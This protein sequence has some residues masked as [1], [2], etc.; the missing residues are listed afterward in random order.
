MDVVDKSD[1]DYSIFNANL[2]VLAVIVDKKD[3]AKAKK[4][5]LSNITLKL[6][7]RVNV[8]PIRP[9]KE[10][11]TKNQ[12]LLSKE[13]TEE[14]I[15]A[16]MEPTGLTFTVSKCTVAL[17]YSKHDY[18]QALKKLLPA[19]LELPLSFETVGHLAHVNLLDAHG[20]HRF[21]I[22]KVFL[23]KH[24][25]ITTVVNKTSEISNEFRV[26]PMEVIG[27][28]PDFEVAVKEGGCTFQL[29]FSKVYWNS[30]LGTEHQRL[31]GEITARSPGKA[32]VA[33]L[34]CGVGP[35]V[36]PL[37]K[38]GHEVYG[39]DLNPDSVRYMEI[40]AKK[41][42]PEAVR[43]LHP[44]LGDARAYMKELIAQRVPV[45]DV[46]MN[47]PA[48]SHKFVDVH[49]GAYQRGDPLPVIHAYVFANIEADDPHTDE[50][51]QRVAIDLV[52][53]ELVGSAST[54]S[55]DMA[56]RVIRDVAPNK[57]MVLVEFMVPDHVGYSTKR[58]E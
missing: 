35:F 31:A 56:A 51:F 12:I 55:V 37:L 45:T 3:T 4:A 30:R 13:S 9:D 23:D 14:A 52:K 22:A 18:K 46:I 5:L 16:A 50:N 58:A 15:N 8:P 21:N 38:A 39:N 34:F 48:M 36:V 1:I 49:V 25:K 10:D 47:L 19:G 40:N 2:E 11:T 41:N 53:A 32:V 29:D 6:I 24:P 28:R 20:P 57:R 33:D 43:R 44:H 26:F 7:H 17:D 54:E 42:A 27:G